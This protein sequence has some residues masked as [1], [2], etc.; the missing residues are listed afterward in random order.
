M[1]VKMISSPITQLAS[2]EAGLRLTVFGLAI[3]GGK[4]DKMWVGRAGLR[5]CW[6]HSSGPVKVSDLPW[7]CP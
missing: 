3:T 1:L 2:T 7:Q 5:A 6:T 4:Y